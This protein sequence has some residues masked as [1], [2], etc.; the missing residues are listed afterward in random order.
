MSDP[1][2]S[3]IQ[4]LSDRKDRLAKEEQRTIEQY[5]CVQ[6]VLT[7]LKGVALPEGLEIA[8]DRWNVTISFRSIDLLH[9]LR[10]LLREANLWGKDC[11]DTVYHGWGQTC[12]AHWKSEEH[13]NLCLCLQFEKKD[14]P[15]ALTKGGKCGWT[16]NTAPEKTSTSWTCSVA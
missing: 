3:Y 15:H 12:F 10:V 13:E 14:T 4:D 7:D 1:V 16:E 2:N 8:A 9:D 11:V 6:N 5:S